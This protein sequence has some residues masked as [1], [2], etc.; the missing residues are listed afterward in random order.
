MPLPVPMPQIKTPEVIKVA[1]DKAACN[2]G[3]GA[4]GHPRVFLAFAPNHIAVCPYCSRV[5]VPE[6]GEGSQGHH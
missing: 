6:A 4:L 1:G 5:F 3:G 2:G